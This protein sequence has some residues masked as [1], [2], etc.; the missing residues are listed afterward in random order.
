MSRLQ[1]CRAVESGSGAAGADIGMEPLFPA[2]I[3]GGT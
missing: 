2:G 3:S 1:V